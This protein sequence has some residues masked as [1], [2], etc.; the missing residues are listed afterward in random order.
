MDCALWHGE[1]LVGTRISRDVIRGG[2]R[3]DEGSLMVDLAYGLRVREA[4]R[5][6]ADFRMGALAFIELSRLRGGAVSDAPS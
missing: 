1:S 6:A 4:R 3:I 2:I 5:G